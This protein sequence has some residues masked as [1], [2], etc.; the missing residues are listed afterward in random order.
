MFCKFTMK[1]TNN[2]EL[3]PI[4][5]IKQDIILLIF[6]MKNIMVSLFPK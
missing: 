5:K 3:K 2:K 1:K 4:K 6:P